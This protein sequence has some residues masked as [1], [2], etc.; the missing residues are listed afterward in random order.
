VLDGD[1]I[2]AVL[3]EQAVNLQT[4]LDTAQAAC[5]TPDPASEGVCQVG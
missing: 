4:V 3:D 5:W 1:D 2:Q